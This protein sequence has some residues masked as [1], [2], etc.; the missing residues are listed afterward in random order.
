MAAKLTM[1][2]QAATSAAEGMTVSVLAGGVWTAVTE[3]F[4]DQEDGILHG[5]SAEAALA[6]DISEIVAVR[7]IAPIDYTDM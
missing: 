7:T 4:I 1:A 5:S 2:Q 6:I 3:I